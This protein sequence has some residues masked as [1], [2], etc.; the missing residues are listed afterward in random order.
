[1]RGAAPGNLSIVSP[2]RWVRWVLGVGLVLNVLWAPAAIADD[3]VPT[4][5]VFARVNAMRAEWGMPP[6]ENDPEMTQGCRSHV[7]YLHLNG[8]GE[9][10]YEDPN[11]PGYT[12]LGNKAAQRS[13]GGF[14]FFAEESPSFYSAPAHRFGFL[15]P[16]PL[17]AGLAQRRNGNISFTCQ[18]YSGFDD[19]DRRVVRA[20]PNPRA[21]TVP[22]DGATGVP[23]W[24]RASELPQTPAHD[25]GLA[26]DPTKPYISGYQVFL[27]HDDLP[28]PAQPEY[29]VVMTTVCRSALLGPGGQPVEA[30]ILVRGILV[31]ASPYLPGG[32]YTPIATYS[33]GSDDRANPTQTS[34]TETQRTASSSFTT[35]A[36][37]PIEAMLGLSDIYFKDGK[38]FFDTTIDEVLR[39]EQGQI[40]YDFTGVYDPYTWDLDDWWKGGRPP[41]DLTTI[42]PGQTLSVTLTSP[43]VRLGPACW[44]PMTVQRAYTRTQSGYSATPQTFT[45]ESPDPCSSPP[46]PKAPVPA[47]GAPGKVVRIGGPGVTDATSVIFGRV[48]ATAWRVQN[49]SLLVTVPARAKSGP[50]RVITP[51]GN[52]TATT[53]FNI[54]K[55]DTA[56]PDTRIDLAPEPSGTARTAHVVFT[57]TEGGGSFLCSLDGAKARRCKS[58]WVGSKLKIGNHKLRVWARDKAGNVDPRPAIVSWS[59]SA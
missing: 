19:E 50:V 55:R 31:P 14:D 16:R 27:Y 53:R 57:S 32:T 37:K 28:N 42:Q 59:I 23:T 22:N 15:D 45:T 26:S 41:Q 4:S 52:A 43:P 33:T 36:R 47:G 56:P 7:D 5:D 49:E 1:M 38:A 39:L 20:A 54:P 46:E 9:F 2:V 18:W 58:P 29:P 44:S 13:N 34:C 24:E 48:P 12:E 30:P 25:V 40:R 8:T 3:F 11:K 17:T 35:E 51:T 10:H 21:W 6:V